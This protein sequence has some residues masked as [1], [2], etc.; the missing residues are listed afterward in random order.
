MGSARIASQPIQQ[1]IQ[2]PQT[3]AQREAVNAAVIHH[4]EILEEG[5]ITV[6]ILV[7]VMIIYLVVTLKFNSY[8]DS[9]SRYG[10]G[11]I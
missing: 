9:V 5:D 3:T 4:V 1:P 8:N 7:T 6:I 2:Q 10:S 11:L